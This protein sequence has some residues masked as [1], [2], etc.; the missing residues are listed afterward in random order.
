MFLRRGKKCLFCDPLDLYCLVTGALLYVVRVYDLA[1]QQ[2]T[3]L[4]TC[5][6]IKALMKKDCKLWHNVYIILH[7]YSNSHDFNLWTL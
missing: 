3:S 1:Q 6:H 5:K 4:T 7:I 2:Q